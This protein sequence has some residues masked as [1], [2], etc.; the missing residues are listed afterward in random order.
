MLNQNFRFLCRSDRR[1]VRSNDD[2]RREIL[3]R[4]I[5]FY[6][7][8]LHFC[9]K[10]KK[11]VSNRNCHRKISSSFVSEIFY[12]GEEPLDFARNKVTEALETRGEI[13]SRTVSTVPPYL[14]DPSVSP[15]DFTLVSGKTKRPNLEIV[16]VLSG[17]HPDL[18]F[19]N[20]YKNLDEK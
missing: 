4:I 12:R 17:D 9:I 14:V 2:S 8:D 7:S 18:S 6:I 19:S 11:T 16:R 15:R 13:S 10:K 3:D 1:H 5:L 20:T